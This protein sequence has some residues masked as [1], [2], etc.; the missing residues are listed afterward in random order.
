MKPFVL[1]VIAIFTFSNFIMAQTIDDAARSIYAHRYNKAEQQLHSIIQMDPMN[2]QAWYYLCNVYMEKNNLEGLS[3]TLHKMPPDLMNKPLL[4]AAYGH[5]LMRQNDSVA[6]YKKFEEVLKDTKM[7]DP[8]V[9][10]EVANAHIDVKYGNA[11]YALELLEKAIKKNK[12]NLHLYI[13]KGDAFRK[14]GDGGNAY[15]AYNEALTKD[16]HY[17]IAYYKIGKIYTSQ[18]N[19]DQFLPAFEKAVASDPN[20]APALYELY[21]YYYFNNANRA[22]DYLTKYIAASDENISNDFLVTDLLYAQGK[23]EKSVENALRLYELFP[24]QSQRMN[25]LIAYSYK[26]LGKPQQALLYLNNYLAGGID[27]GHALNDYEMA[28]N[29]Y[30]AIEGQEDSAAVYYAK[31]AALQTDIE[32]KSAYYKKLAGLY[33]L[34]KDHGNEAYWLGK[35]YSVIKDPSNVDLFNWAIATY[36]NKDYSA[37]D[38]LFTLYETKY[39]KEEFGYYW[40]ARSSAAIDTSMERGL[41]IPHYTGLINLAGADSSAGISNKHLVEAYGYLAAFEANTEKNYERAIGYF[42]KLLELEPTNND[43]LR[44]VS[45]LKKNLSKGKGTSNLADK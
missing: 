37:A 4:T 15:K 6:A 34:R 11:S 14:L 17:A 33:K 26:E 31:A 16:E 7:K 41:A 27:S 19:S 9:L 22:M 18:N 13:L 5:L 28:G 12:S 8:A 29:I 23:Y 45:I 21:Y 2:Q 38:S 30:A 10:A 20:Y 3:D 40:G 39:P 44:Y 32:K 25:K 1:S 36:L 43:A 42:E 24:A 35:Y